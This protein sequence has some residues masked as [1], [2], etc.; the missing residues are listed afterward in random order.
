MEQTAKTALIQNLLP[1]LI[2][3]GFLIFC[4][5]TKGKL[6]NENTVLKLEIQNLRLQ[7]EILVQKTGQL[8][9]LNYTRDSILKPLLKRSYELNYKYSQSVDT[10]I[11]SD[12]DSLIQLFTRNTIGF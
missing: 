2:L 10:S 7:T 4:G 3:V 12:V 1:P 8:V 9:E 5:V 11:V 6:K